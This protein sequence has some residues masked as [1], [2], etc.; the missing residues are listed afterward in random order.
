MFKTFKMAEALEPLLIKERHTCMPNAINIIFYMTER[1]PNNRPIY[2]DWR[3]FQEITNHHVVRR[4]HRANNVDEYDDLRMSTVIWNGVEYIRKFHLQSNLFGQQT[5]KQII[6]TINSF[7]VA[8]YNIFFLFIFFSNYY[9]TFFKGRVTKDYHRGETSH[10]C[11]SVIR[12]QEQEWQEL[13]P[14]ARHG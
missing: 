1:T 3:E 4:G 2:R 13:W 8:H 11:N 6:K 7:M 9:S 14:C 5:G 12:V 10:I